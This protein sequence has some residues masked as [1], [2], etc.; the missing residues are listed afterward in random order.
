MVAG[1]TT[2]DMSNGAGKYQQMNMA[3]QRKDATGG[4]KNN[5]RSQ[6]GMFI[7]PPTL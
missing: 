1:K 3:F 6:N 7:N 2:N 5:G 4:G